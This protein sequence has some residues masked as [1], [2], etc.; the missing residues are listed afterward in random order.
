MVCSCVFIC[1]TSARSWKSSFEVQDGAEQGLWAVAICRPSSALCL[2]TVGDV[3]IDVDVAA[4][5][6]A[7]LVRKCRNNRV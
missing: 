2:D 4:I 1:S 3:V 7:V 5:R 6:E